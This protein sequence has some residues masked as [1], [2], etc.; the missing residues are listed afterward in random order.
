MLKTIDFIGCVTVRCGFPD[1]NRSTDW[2]NRDKAKFSWIFPI[3]L[4]DGFGSS[5][6][7]STGYS[8]RK[9]FRGRRHLSRRI[10][11]ELGGHIIA[12]SVGSIPIAGKKERSA[13]VQYVPGRSQKGRGRGP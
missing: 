3:F 12:A 10:L 9:P 5:S 4:W 11:N 8:S 7:G 2:K 6:Y 13:T 1:R